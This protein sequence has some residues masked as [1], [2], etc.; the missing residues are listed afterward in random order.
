MKC[1]SIMRIIFCE[2]RLLAKTK[3]TATTGDAST[4]D[5]FAR[6]SDC[7]AGSQRVEFP[8]QR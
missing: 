4:Q 6:E 1:R 5:G 3:R 2:S 8:R 7:T